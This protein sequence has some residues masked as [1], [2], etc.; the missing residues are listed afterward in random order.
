MAPSPPPDP[1]SRAWALQHQ[2]VPAAA[3]PAR[4]RCRLLPR[5]AAGGCDDRGGGLDPE[6][7]RGL[8]RADETD[9]ETRRRETGGAWPGRPPELS[10]AG[11]RWPG[12][13]KPVLAPASPAP[14]LSSSLSALL[15]GGHYRGAARP[16]RCAVF[17]PRRRGAGARGGGRGGG[18]CH[19]EV[20]ER[21]LGWPRAQGSGFRPQAQTS[22]EGHRLTPAGARPTLAPAVWPLPAT[23][24]PGPD[25]NHAARQA[26]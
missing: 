23:L 22:P 14:R 25:S 9:E 13:G 26:P 11:G 19:G 6:T 16:L 5:P 1:L 10:V 4:G 15:M 18:D 12:L 3:R 24:S 7:A 17:S 2:P 21:E 8:P 20:Q